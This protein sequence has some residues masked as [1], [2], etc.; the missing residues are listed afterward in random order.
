[1]EGDIAALIC[2]VLVKEFTGIRLA[3]GSVSNTIFL[4]AMDAKTQF[5][6]LSLKYLTIAEIQLNLTIPNRKSLNLLRCFSFLR[7]FNAPTNCSHNTLPNSISIPLFFLARG[8]VYCR[9]IPSEALFG[10]QKN[11]PAA[12]LIIITNNKPL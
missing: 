8:S 7:P 6:E 9:R 1:M 12:A 10:V 11:Q 5:S 3:V 2:L 4:A